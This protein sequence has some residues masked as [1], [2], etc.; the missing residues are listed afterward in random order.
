MKQDWIY[1]ATFRQDADGE[2]IVTFEDLP[3]AITGASDWA[4]A[5]ALAADVLE[6]IVLA[7]LADG[8]AVPAPSPIATSHEPVPLD[9]VTAA[10]AAL[11]RAMRDDGVSN[12][13][14]AR[15]LGKTEGAVRRLT[16]GETGVKID[17]V[18]DA[19]SMMGRR[20]SLSV[21]AA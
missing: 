9:P 8:R 11:A 2:I 7:Y 18:L 17:T 1:P 21:E 13:A 3:E 5:Y 6:E 14:L 16:N 12:A 10:R 4:E 20:A 19:L 15:R